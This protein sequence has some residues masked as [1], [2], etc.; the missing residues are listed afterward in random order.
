MEEIKTVLGWVINTW[1]MLICPPTDKLS[2]WQWEITTILSNIWVKSKTLESTIGRLNHVANIIPVM[3]HFLGHLWKAHLYSLKTGWTSL[4][5]HARDDLKLTTSFLE[6]ASQGVSI[7]NVVF[8][9]P[10]HIYRSDASEFGRIHLRNGLALQ[11]PSWLS[12]LYI[13]EFTWIPSLCD[14]Y[15]VRF[16]IEQCPSWIMP[17]GSNQQHHYKVNGSWVMRILSLTCFLMI[18]TYQTTNWIPWL[19]HLFLHSFPLV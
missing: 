13:A 8:R 5:I 17:I 15:L 12:P 2:K 3:R 16:S 11:N 14:Y 7:N 4:N 18:F 10:T 6:T 1:Q 19:S 9:K